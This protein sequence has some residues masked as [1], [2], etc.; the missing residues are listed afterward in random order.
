[1]V[2]FRIDHVLYIVIELFLY[3]FEVCVCIVPI[4]D[5]L[6][7]MDIVTPNSVVHDHYDGF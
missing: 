1:M 5:V 2:I 6:Y 3:H 4:Y 7:C